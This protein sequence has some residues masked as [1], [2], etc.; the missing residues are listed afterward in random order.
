[1][2]AV[3]VGTAVYT[4]ATTTS[5]KVSTVEMIAA[6]VGLLPN[7]AMT[8]MDQL[9]SERPVSRWIAIMS[10]TLVPLKTFTCQITAMRIHAGM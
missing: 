1:M 7:G 6:S 2:D 3:N 9:A 5:T 4:I 8:N 10:P